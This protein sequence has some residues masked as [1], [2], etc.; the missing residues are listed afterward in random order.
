MDAKRRF[1]QEAAVTTTKQQETAPTS[2][3][4]PSQQKSPLPRNTPH[5]GYFIVS[6]V[7]LARTR[8]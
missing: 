1:P 7:Q 3:A 6:G 2:Q 4:E 8:T 5:S